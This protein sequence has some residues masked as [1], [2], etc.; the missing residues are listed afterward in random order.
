MNF[1]FMFLYE[2]LL[3]FYF[4]APLVGVK[5]IPRSYSTTFLLSKYFLTQRLLINT[6]HKTFQISGFNCLLVIKYRW[7][8]EMRNCCAIA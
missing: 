1:G 2:H 5:L 8:A 3:P 6:I 4:R 7:N